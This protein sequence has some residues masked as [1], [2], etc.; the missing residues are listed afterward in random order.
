MNN[1]SL[2][3]NENKRPMNISS[4]SDIEASIM[5]IVWEKEPIT[6]REVHEIL[7]KNELDKKDKDYIPYTTVMSV[8]NKLAQKGLLKQDKSSKVYQYSSLVDR[9]ELSKNMIKS[10]AEKLL[11][12]S[13]S[14][15]VTKFLSSD[16]NISLEKIKK[17]FDSLKK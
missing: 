11:D 1:K 6:V 17:I 3:K 14:S 10:I 16:D 9:Q 4:L 5:E 15:M 12:K 7:L 2:A 8:M 13:A